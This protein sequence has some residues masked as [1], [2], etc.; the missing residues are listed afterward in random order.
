MKWL[1]LL[2]ILLLVIMG[3]VY[4]TGREALIGRGDELIDERFVVHDIPLLPIENLSGEISAAAEDGEIMHFLFR[5][6]ISVVG[7]VT[8]IQLR[9]EQ[10]GDGLRMETQWYPRDHWR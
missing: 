8:G 7:S 10:V 2:S 5:A 4:R 1:L 6:R 9:L 3:T